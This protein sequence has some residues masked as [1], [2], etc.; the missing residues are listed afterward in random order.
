MLLAA[1][2]AARIWY[3]V[4]NPYRGFSSEGVFVEIPHGSSLRTA[5]HE[6]EKNGV[7]RSARVF[8]IYARRHFRRRLQA[9][10]YFFDQP[11]NT[12]D[13]FYKLANGDVYSQ[14]FLAHEG[15]T[16]FAI[17]CDLQRSNC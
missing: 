11:V 14:Q 7:V 16:I 6:L 15:E 3:C 17:G 9:G 12:R 5:A 8:E 4:E 2:A 13:V 10:E 1:G